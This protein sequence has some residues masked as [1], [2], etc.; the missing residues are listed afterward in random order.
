MLQLADHCMEL[1]KNKD[2]DAALN[3][4]HEYDS[5]TNEL[6]TLSDESKKRYEH[7]FKMFP[8]L[9]YKRDYYSFQLEGQ[10][11]VKY[12]IVF[13]EADKDNDLPAAKTALMFNPVKIDGSWYLTIKTGDENFDRLKN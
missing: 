13:A 2:I 11:D 7:V 9:D 8:V 6:K 3:S 10:N 12:I 1:L 4:L 5:N